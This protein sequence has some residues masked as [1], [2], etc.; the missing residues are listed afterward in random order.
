MRRAPVHRF[1]LVTYPTFLCACQSVLQLLYSD[2]RAV[3][4][5][6]SGR[7]CGGRDSAILSHRKCD[8]T[9]AF[10]LGPDQE[11]GVHSGSLL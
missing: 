7:I 5:S 6:D 4:T 1:Q 3:D 8:L 2:D 9:R 11:F 10:C